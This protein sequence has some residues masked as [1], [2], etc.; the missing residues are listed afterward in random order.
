[1]HRIDGSGAT[2]DHL[3]T[4]G[5]PVGGIEAT[6][7]TAA[8]ANDVQEN[9]MAILADSAISPTK[10]RANDLL[11]AIKKAIQSSAQLQLGTAF[12]TAG[13]AP[14]FTLT[15][16]PAIA[17]YAAKQRFRVKFHAAGAGSDTVNISGQGPKSLKQYDS[18]GTKVAAIVAANQLTDVEYDGTDLVVLDPLPTSVAR[19]S[20]KITAAG[21]F[22]FNVPLGVSQVL[23]SGCAGGGGGS[24]THT[25]SGSNCGGG[26]GGGAGQPAIK[27]PYAVTPGG[28]VSGVIGTGGGGGVVSGNGNAGTS[29]TFGTLTLAFG[30]GGTIPNSPGGTSAG[31]A[32]GVGYPGGGYGADGG[33]GAGGASGGVGAS[34]PYGGGGCPPRGNG[35]T[36]VAGGNAYGYGAGGSG[37]G[38][39]TQG[40]TAGGSPGGAGAPG[41]LFIEW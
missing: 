23:I 36:S 35:G 25:T 3:F 27:I 7:V 11:D 33:A 5:D 26:G 14:G 18:T 24:G 22:T 34:G 30:A 4:E 38:G 6:V 40:V 12:T 31:G 10:G 29:T 8:W 39:V 41:F 37:A 28:T 1:M 32:G 16:S 20:Q 15:P 19:G 21:A 2:P 17:A 9:I 13:T